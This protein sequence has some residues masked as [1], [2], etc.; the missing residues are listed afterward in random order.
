M[1]P[2]VIGPTDT[3]FVVPAGGGSLEPETTAW[4]AAVSADGTNPFT[5][6]TTQK[7]Y[8]D[9]LIKGIKTDFGL[10]LGSSTLQTVFDRIWLLCIADS[11]G[12]AWTECKYDLVHAQTWTF[13][14]TGSVAFTTRWT[15][16]AGYTGVPSDSNFL[17]TG[18]ILSSFGGV[19]ALNSASLM[20][21]VANA[22]VSSDNTCAIG[23]S[24]G[25]NSAIIVPYMS[26]PGCAFE[27]NSAVISSLSGSNSQGLWV[28]NRTASGNLHLYHNGT[29][30][31]GSPTTDASAAVPTTSTLTIGAQGGVGNISA[32]T[33]QAAAV[34]AGLTAPG[35]TG[36]SGFSYRINQYMISVSA[37]FHY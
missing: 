6:T 14:S 19:Y 32:D 11:G 28:T 24:G 21:M 37:G 13:N 33:L 15:N 17:D 20:A 31:A 22:R 2:Y 34:G 5:V 27:L 16:T 35:D 26:L 23:I 25:G 1:R 30:V 8:V 7:N 29:E 4:V 3:S 18:I 12:N 9:T 36:S 10:S